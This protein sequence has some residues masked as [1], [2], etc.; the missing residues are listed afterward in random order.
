MSVQN[1]NVFEDKNALASF[2]LSFYDSPTPLKIQKSI[3]LLWAFYAGTYGAIDYAEE[4]FNNDNSLR[5]PTQLFDPAFEAWRYGPVDYDIYTEMKQDKLPE[6]ESDLNN[7]I[8][9][10]TLD[11]ASQKRNIYMFLENL[12]SQ[13]N[14]M[15]DFSL[16][17]RT[18]QDKSWLDSYKEGKPHINIPSEIIHDEYVKKLSGTI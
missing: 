13:I 16:V 2:L 14:D 4:N 12:I 7:L 17:N 1:K 5:Y 11:D 8:A 9:Q 18:H 3:Y 10:S 15:D 6:S